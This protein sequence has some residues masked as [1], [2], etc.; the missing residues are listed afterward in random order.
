MLL[1]VHLHSLC[2]IRAAPEAGEVGILYLVNSSAT[3]Q[4]FKSAPEKNYVVL[5]PQTFLVS[6][7]LVSISVSQDSSHSANGNDTVN[8]LI[9]LSHFKGALVYDDTFQ[10]GWHTMYHVL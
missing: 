4:A 3:L 9:G 8:T 10:S 6:G 1:F 2:F 5:I 7:P